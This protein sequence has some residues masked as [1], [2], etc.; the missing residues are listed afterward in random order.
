MTI[1]FSRHCPG[2]VYGR[3]TVFLQLIIH[4]L[5]GYRDLRESTYYRDDPM[6]K[7]LLGLKRLPDVTTIS[8]M[9]KEADEKSIARLRRLL[10][11]LVVDRLRKLALSRVTLDFDGSVRK[12]SDPPHRSRVRATMPARSA[13][14]TSTVRWWKPSV[15]P[16][17]LGGTGPTC[18]WFSGAWR[19]ISSAAVTMDRTQS[20]EKSVV[21]VRPSRFPKLTLMSMVKRDREE[22]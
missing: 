13:G 18:S 4:L 22:F 15:S 3:A 17:S 7:R 12:R 9:L 19:A 8:R 21:L 16:I 11:R 14:P 1:L 10:R 20:S 5:L 6:V 2:K